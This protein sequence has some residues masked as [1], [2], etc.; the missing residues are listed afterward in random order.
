MLRRCLSYFKNTFYLDLRSLAVFRIA[1]GLTVA[2]DFFERASQA[3][4]HYSDTGW[5]PRAFLQ[6]PHTFTFHA[7]SGSENFQWWLLIGSGVTALMFAIGWRTRLCNFLLWLLVISTQHRNGLILE[8]F[9]IYARFLLLWSLFVPMAARFSV[10]ALVR[11]SPFKD[12]RLSSFGVFALILQVFVVYFVNFLMKCNPSWFSG[13]AL[14][15]IFSYLD[16][17]TAFGASLLAFPLLL[18]GLTF[19]LLFAEG[20]APWLLLVPSRTGG[21]RTLFGV[22][23][24]ALHLGVLLTLDVGYFTQLS[25]SAA[26]LFIPSQFWDKQRINAPYIKKTLFLR[27]RWQEVLCLILVVYVHAPH[28]HHAIWDQFP[29]WPLKIREMMAPLKLQ[30]KW[31]LFAIPD[32]HL[33]SNWALFTG[34]NS[35]GRR[36]RLPDHTDITDVESKEAFQPMGLNHRLVKA[37]HRLI[38]AQHSSLRLNYLE[39]LCRES[40]KRKLATPY[41][42]IETHAVTFPFDRLP[43]QTVEH[44]STYLCSDGKGVQ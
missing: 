28:P 33:K 5:F 38:S 39:Y 14:S 2:L 3:G 32:A 10:D 7:L 4:A 31:V 22:V 20:F 43:A 41:E 21:P 27:N 29:N 36:F 34:V 18:K 6:Y 12:N 16:Y 35:E 15:Q 13:T 11:S 40:F 42:R 44:G 17:P 9:D 23:I 37:H 30:Q 1:L 25:L 19:V 24:F 26:L 8:G